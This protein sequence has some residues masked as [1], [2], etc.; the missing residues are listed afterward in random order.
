MYSLGCVL[1]ECVVGEPPFRRNTDVAVV[2]AHLDAEP[3][4][5]SAQRPEL[6]PGLDAVIATA[7]AKDPAAALPDVSRA[8]PRR[9][10]G[11]SR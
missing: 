1:Y 3:P 11:G 2:F 5:A 10:G 8:D 7:L 6:P 9:A 4:A